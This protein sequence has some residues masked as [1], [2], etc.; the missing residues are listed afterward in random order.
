MRTA[1]RITGPRIGG[2]SGEVEG[3]FQGAYCSRRVRL[4]QLRSPALPML[5]TRMP[6]PFKNGENGSLPNRL[7]QWK[8]DCRA[9]QRLI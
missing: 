5:N 8:A 2:R 7:S 1:V 9:A 4:R 6:A 3:S